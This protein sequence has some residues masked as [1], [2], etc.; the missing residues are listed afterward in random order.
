MPSRFRARAQAQATERLFATP[1]ISP[2]RPSRNP[3]KRSSPVAV[4]LAVRAVRRIRRTAGVWPR[5]VVFRGTGYTLLGTSA[6][7]EPHPSPV[8]A[9]EDAP[10]RAQE[11][12]GR[13]AELLL[14]G[15][16]REVLARIVPEDPLDLRARVGA[17]ISE[18]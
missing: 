18:R 14:T 11:P 6:G 3:A 12:L 15:T 8:Q 5:I 1:R 7:V 17:R 13:A 16:P 10:V 9:E 2:F 4:R